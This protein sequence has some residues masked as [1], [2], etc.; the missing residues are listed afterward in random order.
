M[1]QD[2][3]KINVINLSKPYISYIVF[4]W[5]TKKEKNSMEVGDFV[6]AKRT[7]RRNE[8]IERKHKLFLGRIIG[9]TKYFYLVKF[10]DIGIRECYREEELTLADKDNNTE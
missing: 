6:Y 8:I 2:T 7:Y 5:I 10:D 3:S 4:I 1:L 9:K